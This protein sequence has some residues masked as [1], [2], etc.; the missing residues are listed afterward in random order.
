[1]DHQQQHQL[2]QQ[3][4]QLQ[5]SPELIVAPM[6][7]S[8]GSMVGCAGSVAATTAEVPNDPG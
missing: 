2:L 1:M 4:Q 6:T 7:V 3:Q 5:D 8:A